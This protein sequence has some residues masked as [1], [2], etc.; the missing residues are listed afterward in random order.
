MLC[1]TARK[2]IYIYFGLMAKCFDGRA[3]AATH[4][5]AWSHRRLFEIFEWISYWLK[6]YFYL[7]AY[8]CDENSVSATC[9]QRTLHAQFISNCILAAHESQIY[10]IKCNAAFGQRRIVYL[11]AW[12]V[13]NIIC[14][15]L[16]KESAHTQCTVHVVHICICAMHIRNTSNR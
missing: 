15:C 2:K 4:I 11:C 6:L 7:F 1:V 8:R 13:L 9:G 10:T 16:F 12:F 5:F 3:V 14:I